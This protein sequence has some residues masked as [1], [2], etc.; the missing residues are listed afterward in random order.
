MSD[1]DAASSAAS[2]GAR[3]LVVQGVAGDTLLGGDMLGV[4]GQLVMTGYTG[5]VA[6][7]STS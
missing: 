5:A 6:N 3:T 2:A 7:G 4:N 1:D